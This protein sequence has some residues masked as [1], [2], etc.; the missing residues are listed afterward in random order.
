[1]NTG[2]LFSPK[3]IGR[4]FAELFWR[5]GQWLLWLLTAL[6]AGAV[7]IGERFGVKNISNHAWFR[8]AVLGAIVSLA[9]AYHRTRLEREAARQPHRSPQHRSSAAPHVDSPTSLIPGKSLESPIS[10]KSEHPSVISD[11]P[12]NRSIPSFRSKSA[13]PA[14]PR[15]ATE[16][17]KPPIPRLPRLDRFRVA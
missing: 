3:E 4:S 8:I 12:A 7:G 11:F 16:A 1:M 6:V 14:V 2:K 9:V 13:K 17:A 5:S 15:F 10:R